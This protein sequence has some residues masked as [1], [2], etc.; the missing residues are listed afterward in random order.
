MAQVRAKRPDTE[1]LPSPAHAAGAAKGDAMSLFTDYLAT[2]ARAL[3]QIDLAAVQRLALAMRRV[4]AA[5]GQVLMCGN[6]GSA[7]NA[8][9]LCNDLIYGV[10]PMGGNGIRALA[11]TANPS[12]VTCL[13]NDVSY[14]QIFAYQVAVQGRAGDLLVVFSGS[15]NSPNVVN[16]LVEARKRGLMTA[17][18][19]GFT[20]G[21]CLA[22]SDIA[23]HVAVEDM[24]VAEDCQQLIGHMVARWLA[25]NRPVRQNTLPVGLAEPAAIPA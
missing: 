3:Q 5:G 2:S 20:G 8:I 7:A 17:S 4:W 11:L 24:Q 25:E 13:A 18:I 19:L 6:G 10:S 22:L 14:D 12:V 21:K 9:H 23:I 1:V 16:A 15:G